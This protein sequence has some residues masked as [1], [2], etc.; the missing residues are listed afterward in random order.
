[1]LDYKCYFIA[2]GCI[3]DEHDIEAIDDVGA[4]LAANV[5]ILEIDFLSIEVWQGTR[6]V[7]RHAIAPNITVILGGKGLDQE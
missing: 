3:R 7:G 6:F 5:L 1:M 2:G 4:L